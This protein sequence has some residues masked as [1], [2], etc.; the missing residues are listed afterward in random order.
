M[1]FRSSNLLDDLKHDRLLN[2][3]IFRVISMLLIVLYHCMCYNAG[4]WNYPSVEPDNVIYILA[5]I[6]VYLALPFF[7][8]ISGYLYSY[9]YIYKNGY[10][11]WRKFLIS[12]LKRL[13]LP[14]ISWTIIYYIV[15][16]SDFSIWE[17]LSGIRHLWFLPTLFCVFIIAKIISPVFF[18]KGK[19][20]IDILIGLGLM[21]ISIVI[22][23]K[24]GELLVGN[25]THYIVYFLGGMILFKHRIFV[26]N[27]SFA[28]AL[29][30]LLICMHCL[31][32]LFPL[33]RFQSI[34]DVIIVIAIS[35]L[36]LELLTAV[37]LNPDSYK[38][39]VLKNLDKN[40]MGIYLVHQVL[41]MLLFEYSLFEELW[42]SN[43]S[44]IGPVVLFMLVFPMSWFFA[45][46]KR[47]LKLEP[48]L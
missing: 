43:H 42:L 32:L 45:A 34:V 30:L 13:I 12:K 40:S 11:N 47:K 33:F 22:N 20:F 1:V 7:F 17:L 5:Q 4:I 48:F 37:R 15:I 26:M 2:I 25:L 27:R 24:Y 38:T 16:P 35:G 21:A 18:L 23:R 28:I 31:I 8:F 9:I 3:S 44:Y 14:T 46:V 41:I 36:I 6:I 10:R 29:L 39:S 19:P